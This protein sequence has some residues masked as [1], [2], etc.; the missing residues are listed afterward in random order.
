MQLLKWPANHLEEL[1]LR[2]LLAH[3]LEDLPQLPDIDG[4]G[5]ILVE[6]QEGVAA[7]CVTGG[8]V[9]RCV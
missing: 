8:G 2:R 4:P 1:L 6:G 9:T 7:A 3:G 5:P